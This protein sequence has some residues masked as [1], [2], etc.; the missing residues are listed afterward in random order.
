MDSHTKSVVSVRTDATTG[1]LVVTGNS[2][3]NLK[4]VQRSFIAA[5][6]LRFPAF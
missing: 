6:T 4:S 5:W 3:L 2:Y 1:N